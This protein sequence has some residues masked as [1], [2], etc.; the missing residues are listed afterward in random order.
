MSTAACSLIM[1]RCLLLVG[2]VAPS[3]KTVVPA[4]ERNY[5]RREDLK[6]EKIIIILSAYAG[7]FHLRII[8]V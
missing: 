7:A 4:L 8:D 1:G 3:G 6:S 2:T 5:Y